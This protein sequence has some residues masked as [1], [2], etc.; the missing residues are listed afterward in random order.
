MTDWPLCILGLLIGW[1]FPGA[2]GFQCWYGH[3][4]RPSPI[5]LA[6][7]IFFCGPLIWCAYLVR[8]WEGDEP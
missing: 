5:A 4:D 1:S 7:M 6:A 8:H 3:A 2:L